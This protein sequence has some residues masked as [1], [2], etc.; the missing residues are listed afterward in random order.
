MV[1]EFLLFFLVSL[2]ALAVV[3]TRDPKKQTV[4]LSFYGLLLSLLFLVL[5]APDVA[6]SEVVVGGA[7]TPLML[8]IAITKIERKSR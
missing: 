8:F 6:F 3:L 2:C 1:L 7:I 4:V 5:Q